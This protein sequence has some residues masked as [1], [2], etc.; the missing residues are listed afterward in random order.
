MADVEHIADRAAVAHGTSLPSRSPARSGS[1]IRSTTRAASTP[2]RPSRRRPGR[3]RWR[4]TWSGSTGS[5]A[6]SSRPAAGAT[7]PATQIRTLVQAGVPRSRIAELLAA[8][9]EE[10][11]TPRSWSAPAAGSPRGDQLFVAPDVARYLDEL[12]VA[13]I[14]ERTARLERDLWILLQSAAP[15]QAQQ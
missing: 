5:A 2:T 3:T 11:A 10:M 15:A 13:G 12:R 1:G 9:P 6:R 8:G 7:T 4:P 14:S